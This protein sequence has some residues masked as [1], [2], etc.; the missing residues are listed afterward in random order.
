MSEADLRVTIAVL[1]E[2]LRAKNVAL[3]ALH[4]VWCDGGCAGGTHRHTPVELTE[5][6]VLVAERNTRRLRS[7][8]QNHQFKERWKL[9]SEAERAQWFVD[10]QP[11]RVE[12]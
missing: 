9:M 11:E 7:W 1:Q 3:D 12:G 10:Q 5:E 4:W 2:K 8:Y 6:M